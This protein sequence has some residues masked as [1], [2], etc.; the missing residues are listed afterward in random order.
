MEKDFGVVLSAVFN[1]I[2]DKAGQEAAVTFE[3]GVNK[4]PTQEQVE[5]ALQE[6][7]KTLNKARLEIVPLASALTPEGE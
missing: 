5:A 1:L 2:S 6:S 7:V 3:F 4:V